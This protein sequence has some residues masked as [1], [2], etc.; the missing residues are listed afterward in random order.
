MREIFLFRPGPEL[1]DV[2]IGLDRLVPKLQSVFGAFGTKAPNVESPDHVAEMI[3]FQRAAGR[4]GQ[5]DGP[6]RCHE[7]ILIASV[8]AC[9]FQG[10][11]DDL[12]V[13]I[14]QA[15]V[16]AGDRLEIFQHAID[17]AVIGVDLEI[18]RIGNAA[19]QPD[20]LFAEALQKRVVAAGLAGDDWVFKSGVRIGLHKAQRV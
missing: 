9:R 1:T 13:D 5:T 8:A 17:E 11:I 15:S 4:V 19:H 18:E 3:E 16:L 7:L 2:V 12:T 14:E 20:G 6:E 10:S